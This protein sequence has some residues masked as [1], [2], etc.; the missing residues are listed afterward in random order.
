MGEL[1]LLGACIPAEHG[2][3]GADFLSYVLALEEISRGD[4]GLGVTF[5]VHVVRRPA[6]DPRPRHAPSRSTA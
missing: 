1:G 3:A 4:A 2:G 5:A 6:A